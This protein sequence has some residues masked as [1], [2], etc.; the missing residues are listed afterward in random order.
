MTAPHCAPASLLL[1]GAARYEAIFASLEALGWPRASLTLA[2]DFTTATAADTTGR[3]VAMRDDAFRRATYAYAVTT[4]SDH[5]RVGV[6][7]QV[8][9]N[10]EAPVYLNTLDPV[11]WSR[12]ALGSDGLP[13]FT[14]VARFNF[15]IVIPDSVANGTFAGGGGFVQYGHGLFGSQREVEDEYL[16]IFANKYGYVLAA[17]DEVGLA[18]ADAPLAVQFMSSNVT[19]FGYIPDRCHQGVLNELL[20]TRLITQSA[21]RTDAAMV[22]NGVPVVSS[23]RARWHYYGN[24]QGGILGAVYMA[25]TTDVERGVLGVGGGPYSLL[26]ARSVDY[27]PM[28]AALR[29][30]FPR[31]Q[32]AMAVHAAMDQLWVRAEPAGYLRAISAAPLPGTPAHRVVFQH[33]LAD[34]Q[35]TWL[36]V[37]YASYSTG[38]RMF[39]S[40][41][42]Q[43]N[44]SLAHFTRVPDAA[45]VSDGNLAMTWDFNSPAWAQPLVNLPPVN[46]SADTHGW[47]RQQPT[48]QAQM[49]EFFATGGIINTCGGRCVGTPSMSK[50]PHVGPRRVA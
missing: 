39:A 24:S 25:A 43:G 12:L 49:A 20:A 11:P 44:E 28:F 6:A 48:A 15:T 8:E 16:T 14:G 19:D 5:P 31:P 26:L 21:L 34:A 42:G 7:R 9:G 1:S 23:D 33:G 32:D 3:L 50:L 29:E 27:A 13:V 47:T 41:A 40:N 45:V 36:G 30:A 38:A 22:F 35:V 37:R 10:F 4:V 46:S 17:V 18:E 2:W